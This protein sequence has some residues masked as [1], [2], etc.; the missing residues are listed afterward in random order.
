[1]CKIENIAL[2]MEM[3]LNKKTE[4]L[5]RMSSHM[6]VMVSG[7]HGSVWTDRTRH[8]QKWTTVQEMSNKVNNLI[9]FVEQNES[10]AFQ[11]LKIINKLLADWRQAMSN[12]TFKFMLKQILYT[13]E[14]FR[15]VVLFR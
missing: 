12:P 9:S 3:S 5:V 1:M 2:P 15:Y 14:S 6:H 10:L 13:E 8:R 4:R 7:D 11:G